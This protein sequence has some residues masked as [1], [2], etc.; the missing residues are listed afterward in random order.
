MTGWRKSSHCQGGACVEAASFRKAQGCGN[1]ECVEVG[2]GPGIVAARD[3]T[4]RGTVLNFSSVSWREFT[5]A[6]KAGCLY[7]GPVEASR[8]R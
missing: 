6:L 7:R 1:T 3:S 2:T 5:A 8:E 4:D